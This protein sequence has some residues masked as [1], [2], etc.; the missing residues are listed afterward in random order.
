MNSEEDNEKSKEGENGQNEFF[1]IIIVQAIAPQTQKFL[2]HFLDVEI[3]GKSF[4]I[5]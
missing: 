5:K 1:F 2:F 4:V 3:F